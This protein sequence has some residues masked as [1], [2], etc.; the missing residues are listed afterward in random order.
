MQAYHSA[1]GYSQSVEDALDLLKEN[2]PRT[3]VN[4]MEVIDVLPV[5]DLA[6]VNALCYV[7]IK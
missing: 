6:S 7:A 4:V 2:L 3:L 5:A 1:A